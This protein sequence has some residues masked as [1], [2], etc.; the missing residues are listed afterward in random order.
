M[1]DELDMSAF[2]AQ[3][4]PEPEGPWTFYAKF[5]SLMSNEDFERLA[6]LRD[7]IADLNE[8]GDIR[9]LIGYDLEFGRLEVQDVLDRVRAVINALR[10]LESVLLN[11]RRPIDE[12]IAHNDQLIREDRKKKEAYERELAR[13]LEELASRRRLQLERERLTNLAEDYPWRRGVDGKKALP[14]QVEGAFRLVSAERA[15]LGDK[16]G[17]GKTLQ[18]IMTIDMLRATGKGKKVLIFTPKPVIADFKRAFERWTNKTFV[19]VLNQAV[20]GVSIKTEILEVIRHMPEAIVITNYEVWRKDRTILEKLKDCAFD[21]VIFDEAH[22]LKGA[23]SKTTQDIQELVY[24]E[25]LCPKCGSQDFVSTVYGT[26]CKQC[27]HRPDEFGEFCSVKNVYPMTGTPILNKPQELWPLLH[28]IDRV[29][30]P[31]EKDFLDDY[32]EKRY[33]Y[34]NERWYYTFGSGG[35]ERLLKKLGMKY[36][37]R[38]RDSAG[39]KMPPQE[40]KHHWLELD[41]EKYPRQSNFIQ[42]LRDRARLAFS[43]TEQMTT[44]AILAWYTRMRQAASWPDGIRILGCNHDPVCTDE[45]GLPGVCIKPSVVFPKPG[46]P[47]IG[48]SVMMD[49]AEEIVSEAVE[50]GDRIVVFSMYRPVIE[51]LER[52]AKE[53]NLRVGKIYGGVPDKL[54]QEYIDDFNT[55]HTKVGEH[56]YD[57]LICQYQTAS[58]GLNLNGAQQVLCI[59]REWNPGKEEQTFDRVRRI[60]S[61]YESIVHVLHCAGTATELIDAIIDQK[62]RMLKGFEDDVNLV[63]AMR[64]FLEG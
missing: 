18:A 50:E 59:E 11:R 48:E 62:E 23:K 42:Q 13:L 34:E 56:K 57:V 3:F 51:E 1:A 58:V 39:V 46:T 14:H 36:T 38:T 9:K 4:D 7:A 25:N 19:H 2:E 6:F 24:A 61:E 15:L 8:M 17:L 33:D 22:V 63:E 49:A 55:N 30:F 27:E 37:A 43:E 21:T 54:R 28:M 10:V 26:L 32:C 35:S 64:K 40:V 20:K 5:S 52:R 31:S 41:P 47:P 45:L 12:K 60:D 44:D 53:K 29:G 16:P